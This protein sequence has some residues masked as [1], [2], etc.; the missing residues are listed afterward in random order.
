MGMFL[1]LLPF[2]NDEDRR[3]DTAFSKTVLESGPALRTELFEALSSLPSNPVPG[4]FITYLS[5]EG[6][7]EDTHYG[8]TQTNGYDEPLKCV[9]VAQLLSLSS[10]ENVRDNVVSKAVWAYLSNLSRN[11]R[12]ALYWY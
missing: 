5:R 10:H 7:S 2:E 6:E 8:N 1:A 4:A 3:G 9:T 12:V 11:T